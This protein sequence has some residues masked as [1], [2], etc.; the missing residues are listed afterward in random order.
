MTSLQSAW[1]YPSHLRVVE[2]DETHVVLTYLNV[3]IVLWHNFPRAELL[4]QLYNCAERQ[5]TQHSVPKVSVVSILQGRMRGAP[6]PAAR[7]ALSM[8]HRDP[9]SILHRFA[10]VF[11]DEGFIVANIRSILLSVRNRLTG[12]TNNEVF[13][14]YEEAVRWI[15]EGLLGPEKQEL[16][17][18]PIIAELRR[19]FAHSATDSRVC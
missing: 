19:H 5:A 16:S 3:I 13:K 6:S 17:A 15:V 1:S 14:S 11:V 12:A 4:H 10:L 7:A 9:K 8:L 18:A 2:A